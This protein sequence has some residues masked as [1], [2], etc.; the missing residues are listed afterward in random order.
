[1]VP[2]A[3]Q[4]RGLP[5]RRILRL[6]AW[7]GVSSGREDRSLAGNTPWPTAP[8]RRASPKT[9]ISAQLSGLL[10]IG[11]RPDRAFPSPAEDALNLGE[12]AV[13]RRETARARGRWRA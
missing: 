2:G 4:A 6:R 13:S 1:M 3:P 5:S 12:T 9:D 10:A 7:L 11:R 8:E